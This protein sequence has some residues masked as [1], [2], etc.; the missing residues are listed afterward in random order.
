MMCK[1]K[2]KL[3]KNKERKRNVDLKFVGL[4][5]LIL[6]AT[7]KV[8]YYNGKPR[9]QERAKFSVRAPWEGEMKWKW[10]VWKTSKHPYASMDDTQLLWKDEEN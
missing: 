1:L 4:G 5:F 3:Y 8:R 6:P 9:K 7:F 2:N 10:R